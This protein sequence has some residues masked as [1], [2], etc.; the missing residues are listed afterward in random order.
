MINQLF[1]KMIPID[2]LEQILNC[3]NLKNLD[4]AKIFT[5]YDLELNNT[6]IKIDMLKPELESYF[7]LSEF[8]HLT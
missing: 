3:F 1:R 4:D 7:L 2:L 5:K 6:V 8:Y